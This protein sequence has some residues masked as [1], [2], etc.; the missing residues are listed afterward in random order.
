VPE[1]ELEIMWETES[2]RGSE[3]LMVAVE[4]SAGM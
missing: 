3:E 1:L 2:E 4:D